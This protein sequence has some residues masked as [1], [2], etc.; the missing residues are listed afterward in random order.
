MRESRAPAASAAS[1]RGPG[2]P[3]RS[4]PVG[5]RPREEVISHHVHDGLAREL[6]REFFIFVVAQAM[7]E[8]SASERAVI[9]VPLDTLRT[10]SK[11]RC[12]AHSITE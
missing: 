4:G 5:P 3:A 8:M 9:D 11:P 2:H 6:K 10:V 7:T 12:P 1:H